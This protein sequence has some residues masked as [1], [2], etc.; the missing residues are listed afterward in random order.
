[1][2]SNYRSQ[3]FGFR[4]NSALLYHLDKDSTP[5]DWHDIG[6]ELEYTFT[7]HFNKIV[8]E[9]DRVDFLGKIMEVFTNTYA[10]GDGH[11]QLGVPA[12]EELWELL[13][14]S[15]G[16]PH[17]EHNKLEPPFNNISGF[18]FKVFWDKGR[19]DL[20]IL[21][22]LEDELNN[23]AILNQATVEL[24][25]LMIIPRARETITA[26]VKGSGERE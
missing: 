5:D 13:E 10:L 9:I 25:G 11:Y 1:M 18:L 26:K 14:S 2:S 6:Y 23:V 8:R 21:N 22:R 12:E 20:R 15:F 16:I 17:G 24:V 4:R 19:F 7:V 3:A